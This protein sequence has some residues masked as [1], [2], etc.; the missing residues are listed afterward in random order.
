MTR[1]QQNKMALIF[2]IVGIFGSLNVEI[3][4]VFLVNLLVYSFF[5]PDVYITKLTHIFIKTTVN[6]EYLP[7]IFQCLSSGN[8]V[9]TSTTLTW[10]VEPV[11]GVLQRP[12]PKRR[13]PTPPKYCGR[14]VDGTG[15]IT[16]KIHEEELFNHI[17]KQHPIKFT[18]CTGIATLYLLRTSWYIWFT[19][20]TF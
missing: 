14:Y 7:P 16:K 2:F 13:A 10:L 9:M 17:N 3:Y 18:I 6:L 8:E 15:V 11:H 19:R 5:S 12:S 4:R 1:M 20:T